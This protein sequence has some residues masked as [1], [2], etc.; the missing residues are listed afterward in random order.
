MP[1]CFDSELSHHLVDESHAPV[2]QKKRCSPMEERQI[3]LEEFDG[4]L[5]RGI[6]SPS[7]SPRVAQVLCVRKKDVTLRLC[8]DCRGHNSFSVPDNGDLGEMRGI[9]AFLRSKHYLA[10][11]DL[12]TGFNQ[13][14]ITEKDECK[15]AFRDPDGRF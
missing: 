13:V 4:L 8:V 11:L 9:F 3:I 5:D 6:I 15:T 10:Q 14:P 12:A 7:K 1:A 2:T